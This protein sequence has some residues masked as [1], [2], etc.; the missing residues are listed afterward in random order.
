MNK[1]VDDLLLTLDKQKEIYEQINDLALEKKQVII[2]NNINRLAE[3]TKQEETIVGALIK[4]ENLRDLIVDKLASQY[5]IRNVSTLND[6]DSFFTDEERGKVLQS[7]T[8]LKSVLRN[9]EETNELN[10]KLIEQSL[11]LI[12]FNVNL[13]TDIDDKVKY[14]KNATEKDNDK[15][16]IFDMKV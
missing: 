14:N 1:L 15:R 12:N 10:G 6:L 16:S 4:L 5:G 3:I 7:K 2:D 13:F 11:E 9:I 8:S